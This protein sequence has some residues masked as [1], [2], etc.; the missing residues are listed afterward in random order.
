M[1]RQSEFPYL[2]DWIAILLRWVMLI[3]ATLVLALSTGATWPFIFLLA[4][5]AGW[6][7]ASS[8]LAINNRRLV[9]HRPINVLIDFLISIGMFLASGSESGPLFWIGLLALLSG[10]IYYEWRGSLGVALALSLLQGGAFYTRTGGTLVLESFLPLGRT[11]AFNLLTGGLLGALSTRLIGAVRK[12]YQAQLALRREAERKAQ[13]R[14]RRRIQTFYDMVETLGGTLNHQVVLDAALDLSLAALSEEADIQPLVSLVLVFREEGLV[15]GTARGLPPA[16]QGV[17]LRAREGVLA[18]ILQRGEPQILT[19][20]GQDPELNRLVAL[21]NCRSAYCLPLVRGMQIFGAMLFAHP[22][23]D[24]F[25]PDRCELLEIIG[26]QVTIALQNARLFQQLEEERQRLIETT[27]EAHKKLARD[28]HDGPTQSISAIA[29]RLSILRKRLESGATNGQVTEELKQIE[30][31]ARRTTEEIRHM[32]FTLRPLILESEGLIPALQVMCEKMWALY[33]QKV[34]LDADPDVVKRLDPN[35]QT[36]IFYIIEEAVNNARKHAEASEIRVR[37]RFLPR[38]QEI[39]F[40]EVAD[41]GK[42][43]DPKEVETNYEHR[44]SLGMVN[45]RER[46]ELLNGLLYIDSAPGK[47]TRVYIVIPLTDSAAER[48]HRGLIGTRERA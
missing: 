35:R 42:G 41:N 38:E 16:D 30:A 4:L 1:V 29:M 8:S 20:L 3:T 13:Q 21:Q 10:A 12:R 15:I 11:L 33:Q 46:T 45:L 23:P 6:N 19:Q 27:E 32:L 26:H 22:D 14:E 39:A 48:L 24:F 44:G 37:I 25:T 7:L 40:V 31:L 36:V 18:E 17:I 9:F 5:G 2:A 47:G 28:L 43:F 34:T